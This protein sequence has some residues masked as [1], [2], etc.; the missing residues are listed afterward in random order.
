MRNNRF[1]EKERKIKEKI[2]MSPSKADAYK[3]VEYMNDDIL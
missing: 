2:K 1:L 3:F